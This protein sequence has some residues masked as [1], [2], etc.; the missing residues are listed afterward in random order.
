MN[1]HSFGIGRRGLIA[2]TATL[3]GAPALA[4][5]QGAPSGSPAPAP[6]GAAGNPGGQ[7]AVIDVN[8]ARVQPIPIAIP[9]FQGA[10]DL[11]N[12]IVGVI[13][14]DL[15]NCGLFRPLDPA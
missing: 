7:S 8:H 2:G 15:K 6:S 11:G 4:R 10:S 14:S 1:G 12:Q 13:T 9:T 5:A 3:L